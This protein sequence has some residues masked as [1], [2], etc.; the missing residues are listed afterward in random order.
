MKLYAVVMNRYG[1]ETGHSYCLGFVKDLLIGEIHGI[2]HGTLDR[3]S[4]YDPS[5]QEFEIDIQPNQKYI[6]LLSSWNGDKNDLL[7]KPFL[8]KEDAKVHL[9]T[10]NRDFFE[11]E[12]AYIFEDVGDTTVK[13]CM[14]ALYCFGTEA[15]LYLKNK[16]E[17]I[18]RR[19]HESKAE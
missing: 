6:L 11:L 2:C 5:Y 14:A 1:D 12:Q 18:V 7:I 8:N 10:D 9:L 15:Q 4:K 16:Y 3:G 19:E 17:D 13:E